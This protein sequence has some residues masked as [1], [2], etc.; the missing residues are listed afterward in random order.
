MKLKKWIENGDEECGICGSST[1]VL[2]D[3]DGA[4]YDGASV[5]CI[6]CG[7]YGQWNIDADTSYCT[8]EE[9]KEEYLNYLFLERYIAKD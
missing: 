7:A 4:I 9:E 6:N 2:V 8:C 5:R 3:S 1:Y